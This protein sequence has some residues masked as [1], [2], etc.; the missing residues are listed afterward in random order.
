MAATRREFQQLAK[1]RLR[2]ARILMR[3]GNAEAAYYLTGFAVEC[4]V[5]ACIAKNTERYDFPPDPNA[6]RDIYTHKLGK[7]IAAAK[8]DAALDAEKRSDLSFNNKWDV[9][10]DWDNN[11][12]YT[13]GGLNARDLYRAVAG[14]NGIM[15]W[16]RQHW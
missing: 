3:E 2:D 5:K 11:S 1:M 12:R 14:R 6:I 10:K 7:L 15:Q 8:L 13:V 16:L 4:A 9:V